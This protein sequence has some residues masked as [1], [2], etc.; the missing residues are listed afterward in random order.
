MIRV[1]QA[2]EVYDREKYQQLTNAVVELQK[3][4]MTLSAYVP[5]VDI[6]TGKNIKV[7]VDNLVVEAIEL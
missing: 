4:F 7:Q 1:P 5:Q 2:P 6:T 3:Q